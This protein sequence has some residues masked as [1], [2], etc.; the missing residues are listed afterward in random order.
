MMNYGLIA[1]GDGSRL[2]AEG[3][4]TPK[5]LVKVNGE[6][7]IGR[8]LRIF[9]ANHAASVSIIINS[10]MT[11]VRQYLE[12]LQLDIPLHLVV[13]STPSS[14]HSF[15]EL[16]PFLKEG[17]KF[18]LTTVD[19][20]FR[21]EEFAAY[22]GDFARDGEHDALMGVT[23]FVDDEKPLYVRTEGDTMRIT[24]YASQKGSDTRYISGG[25]YCM[26][27]RALDLL[28]EAMDKGVQRM[29]GFQQY[30]VD[31]G[32]RMQAWRFD[33]VVDIDHARDIQTAE[34]FLR[35]QKEL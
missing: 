19:P 28:P 24:G 7:L 27:R 11:E 20:I 31:A 1:A 3:I 10:Y 8:L 9:R 22:V 4:A 13:K 26:N 29:R 30:M 33:K 2:V 16:M 5:P 6:P 34:E 23:D 14:F 18:C 32:L 25:I 17:D 35:E 15:Y 21:E 12:G